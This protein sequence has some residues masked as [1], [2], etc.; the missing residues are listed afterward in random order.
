MPSPYY[1]V[2]VHDTDKSL[3]NYISCNNLSQCLS[4]PRSCPAKV[5]RGHHS[6]ER[7]GKTLRQTGSKEADRKQRA[8][9]DFQQR[10]DDECNTKERKL[11]EAANFT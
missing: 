8:N 11:E 1:C 2:F 3:L 10:E 7:T 5:R 4:N 9:G 6:T